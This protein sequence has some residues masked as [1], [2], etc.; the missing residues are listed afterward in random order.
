[1]ST[2]FAIKVKDKYVDVAIRYKGKIS[3]INDLLPAVNIKKKVFAIDN[4][5]QGIYTVGDIL[6]QLQ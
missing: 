1:M 2:M 5:P 6:K 4:T 3:L